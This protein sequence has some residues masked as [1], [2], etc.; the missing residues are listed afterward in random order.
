MTCQETLALDL[1]EFLARP[2]AEEFAAFRSHYP[3]CADCAAEVRAWT[4][5][6]ASL[7]GATH[8]SP[9]ALLQYEGGG[10]AD[11][12]RRGIAQHLAGCAPCRDELRAL[13]VFDRDAA[14]AAARVPVSKPRPWS[15]RLPRLV[16]H[17]ALAYGLVLALLFYPA[18]RSRFSET[19][20]TESPTQSDDL[21]P[22]AKL[23]DRS[24]PSARE[25]RAALAKKAA[26]AQPAAEPP[27]AAG[28]SARSDA[29][30]REI[31]AAAPREH[32][33]AL[34]SGVA[35]AEGATARVEIL[36]GPSAEQ[37]TLRIPVSAALRDAGEVHVRVVALP[38][39]R[40]L[41]ERVAVA[42]NR[43]EIQVPRVWLV[44][45][46]Y[47]VELRTSPNANEMDAF[48]LDVRG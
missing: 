34:S 40:E 8:P 46:R 28:G 16:L 22:K 24:V 47:R 11:A 17:P 14:P 31:D 41:Q 45:G 27:A 44:P 5:L 25:E 18:L 9:D 4:E 36:P 20:L 6:Q 39:E 38:S 29:Y 7:S 10:L 32:L 26:P 2:T 21:A 37:K 30:E 33:R 12:E 15:F 43:V 3:R 13:A 1:A 19:Q 35:G 23:A 48:T 42:G